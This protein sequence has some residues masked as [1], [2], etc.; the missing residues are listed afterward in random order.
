MHDL[1]DAPAGEVLQ[2]TGE[3]Q[4][5]EDHGEVGFDR[6]AVSWK[7]GRARRSVLDI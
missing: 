1:L 3:G 6:L 7:I 4:R 2:V 5:C